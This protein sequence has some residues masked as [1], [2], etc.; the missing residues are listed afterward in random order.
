M[1]LVHVIYIRPDFL[2]LGEFV[3]DMCYVIKNSELLILFSFRYGNV[4]VVAKATLRLQLYT[5]GCT[6]FRKN[7]PIYLLFDFL[8]W[9]INPLHF[10]YLF[11]IF[12]CYIIRLQSHRHPIGQL[13]HMDLCRSLQG[14]SHFTSLISL[15]LYFAIRVVHTH[16]V[17]HLNNF[18]P[19]FVAIQ[20]LGGKS[21]VSNTSCRVWVLFLNMHR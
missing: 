7:V 9:L 10:I 21:E 16:I 13:D 20:M 15:H 5:G 4:P 2:Q 17:Q 11:I 12:F 1:L 8:K 14:C 3:E 6:Y 18:Q 19:A